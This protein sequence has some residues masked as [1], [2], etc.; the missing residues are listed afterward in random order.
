M[1][2]PR[3]GTRLRARGLGF[4]ARGSGLMAGGSGPG[5]KGSRKSGQSA[6]ARRAHVKRGLRVSG[7]ECFEVRE[8]LRPT[9]GAFF[10][11]KLVEAETGGWL[12][13]VLSAH[14]ARPGLVKG[15]AIVVVSRAMRFGGA[16]S[17]T[18]EPGDV[19]SAAVRPTLPKPKSS[20][21]RMR[22]SAF[23]GVGSTNTSMSFV[24]R[25]FAWNANA[26]P[27]TMT[28]LT[29]R[30]FKHANSS[31]KSFVTMLDGRDPLGAKLLEGGDAL[32][33]R[34]LCPELAIGLTVFREVRARS[35]PQSHTPI[36]ALPDRGSW[37]RVALPGSRRPPQFI[38]TSSKG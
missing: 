20:S 6:M 4:A 8:I 16:P 27:P 28:A 26:Y 11:T 1:L 9:R 31:S 18:I 17:C 33:R 29:F 30:A 15:H 35:Y 37:M 25:G 14:T 5:A 13:A 10:A 32:G 19:K 7:V 2:Q 22:R 36:I 34:Q 38:S 24:K 21:A 3:C 12:R 23:S